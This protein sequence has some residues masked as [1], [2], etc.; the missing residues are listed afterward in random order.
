MTLNIAFVDYIP[1]QLTDATLYVSERF[2]VAI[3]KCACGCGNQ[4]VT[5][6]GRP[7]GWKLI[8]NE[9]GVSLTPSIGNF[10]F[11]CKS[12]YFITNSEVIWA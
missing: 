4:T 9:L 2:G 3:H 7:D 11:P 6:F 5:P 8:K 12:H 1:E 10:Q